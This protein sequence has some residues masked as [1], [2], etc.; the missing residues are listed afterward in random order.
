MA[1]AMNFAFVSADATRAAADLLVLP[2]FDTDLSNKKTANSTLA[3]TDKKTKGALLKLA[4]S[5]GFK[6][7]NEQSFLFQSQGKVPAT[8]V[9]LLGIGDAKNFT[10]E[11]LRQ[12]AGRA[13]KTAQRL[14]VK[15]LS[16]VLPAHAELDALIK[17]TV[18]GLELGE[19]RY[20]R[21][22]TQKKDAAPKIAKVA[23]FL[24]D[25]VKKQK[26]HEQVARS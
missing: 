14:K 19:Y 9:L 17:A 3:A 2:L 5:E 25:G 11:T 18:E 12:A 7:K 6:G 20:D 23:L 8:R 24:P 4:E 10:A 22:K 1:P 16:F 26:S 13:A 21:W 15:N